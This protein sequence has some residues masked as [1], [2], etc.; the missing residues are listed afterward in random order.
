[1]IEPTR[2]SCSTPWATGTPTTS[3]IRESTPW[4]VY[5]HHPPLLL[6]NLHWPL[7]WSSCF[8]VLEGPQPRVHPAPGPRSLLLRTSGSRRC[9]LYRKWNPRLPL[10]RSKYWSRLDS[11]GLRRHRRPLPRTRKGMS[12]P[13]LCN[14]SSLL[15]KPLPPPLTGRLSFL[16]CSPSSCKRTA[17]RALQPSY[18]ST[19]SI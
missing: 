17:V 3:S 7:V 2:C 11:T 19:A 4:Y 12:N 1:M 18:P 8:D 15:L 10:V 13:A 14:P 5:H 16:P 9:L 6:V